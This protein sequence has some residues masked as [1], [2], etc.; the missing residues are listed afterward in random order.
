MRPVSLYLFNNTPGALTSDNEDSNMSKRLNLWCLLKDGEKGF[1]IF[2]V[3]ISSDE[4]VYNL[5]AAI[6]TAKLNALNHFDADEL[7]IWKAEISIVKDAVYDRDYKQS[8]NTLKSDHRNKMEASDEI[9]IYIEEALPKKIQV[10]IELP[11][12]AASPE[13]S[14]SASVTRKITERR[15]KFKRRQSPPVDVDV[16]KRQKMLQERE[17]SFQAGLAT[18]S[19]SSAAKPHGFSRRQEKDPIYNGRP[20]EKSGPPVALFHTVFGEFLRDINNVNLPL[21]NDGISLTEE[22]L[23]DSADIYKREDQHLAKIKGK[24]SVTLWTRYVEAVKREATG[25]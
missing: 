21:T 6:K 7:T 1:T 9:L 2:P 14:T 19:P 16:I 4:W 23:W 17:K 11:E 8:V 25:L 24:F 20:F 10:F 15:C 22:L 18:S 5:Q 13:T 12:Q 3:D